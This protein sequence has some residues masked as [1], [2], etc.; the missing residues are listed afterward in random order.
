MMCNL[1]QD[2]VFVLLGFVLV[3]V[4]VPPAISQL[5]P[6]GIE[7]FILCRDVFEVYNLFSDVT[8]IQI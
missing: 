6:L 2:L 1:I 3:L 7:I 5:F 8:A 4:H